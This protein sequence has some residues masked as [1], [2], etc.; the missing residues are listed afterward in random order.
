MADGGVFAKTGGRLSSH[1]T[2]RC[3][4]GETWRHLGSKGDLW[5][6]RA[7]AACLAY[8]KAQPYG[9]PRMMRA[10]PVRVQRQQPLERLHGRCAS[11]PL[12]CAV[13][14][15]GAACDGGLRGD[16]AKTLLVPTVESI[17]IGSGHA[18]AKAWLAYRTT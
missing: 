7:L 8:T 3:S 16:M 2:L 6:R 5:L 15:L 4:Q 9:G 13:R 1:D 17:E 18:R 10:W 11:S 14:T 12:R